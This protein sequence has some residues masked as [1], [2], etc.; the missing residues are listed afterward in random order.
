MMKKNNIKTYNKKM[1]E[2][3]CTWNYNHD[4]D[5]DDDE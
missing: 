1:I 2:M 4:D 5:D 3:V